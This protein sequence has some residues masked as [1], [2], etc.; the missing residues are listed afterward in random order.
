MQKYLSVVFFD[1][2]NDS[3]SWVITP[4]GHLWKQTLINGVRIWE[5]TQRLKAKLTEDVIPVSRHIH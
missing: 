5:T 4:Q 1:A 2:L 3:D